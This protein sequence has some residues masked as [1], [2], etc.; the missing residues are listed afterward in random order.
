VMAVE[1]YKYRYIIIDSL[2]TDFLMASTIFGKI[3]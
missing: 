3:E 2:S 1:R